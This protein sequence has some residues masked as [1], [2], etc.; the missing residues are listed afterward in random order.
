MDVLRETETLLAQCSRV[1]GFK[2]AAARQNL[3]KQVADG[4]FNRL[5]PVSFASSGFEPAGAIAN[6][7]LSLTLSQRA[8]EPHPRSPAPLPAN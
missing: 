3:L 4:L 5:Q 2:S 8:R 6:K 1:G 7:T